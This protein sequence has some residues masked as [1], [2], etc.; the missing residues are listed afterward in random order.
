MGFIK[1]IRKKLLEKGYCPFCLAKLAIPVSLQV[2]VTDNN[3][4]IHT[5][6]CICKRKYQYNSD[7]QKF[8]AP[9]NRN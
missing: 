8:S 6:S 7:T 5:V 1:A 4:S 3:E 2:S 9:A